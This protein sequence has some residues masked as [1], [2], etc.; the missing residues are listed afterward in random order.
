MY[1]AIFSLVVINYIDRV[2]LSMGAPAI[3]K[4]FN[5]GPVKLGYLFSSYMW[6]YL[7]LLIPWGLM[8]D[9]FGAKKINGVGII[10]WSIATIFS[11]LSTGFGMLLGSR[12]LMG[13]AEASS[14]PGGGRAL[15]D[16]SPKKEYGLAAT[17]LNSGGYAGPALGTFFLGWVLS[18][19]N[20]RCAFYAAALLGFVWFII[21][22]FWYKKPEDA[23]WLS[24]D[25]R[26]YIIRERDNGGSIDADRRTAGFF[27]L[28]KSRTMI[29]IAIAQGCAVYTQIVF[30]T[31]LPSYLVHVKH[32]SIL[33]SGSFTALPYFCATILSWIIAHFS[34]RILA[35]RGSAATGQRRLIIVIAMLT[36]AVILFAPAVQN[37]A[38]ILILITISLT[39]LA[40]GI[41]LNIALTA[42][43][44]RSPADAAKAMSIQ[45]SGGNIFGIAAPIV[46]GYIIALTGGYNMAFVAGGVLLII[47]A[48]ITFTLTRSPIGITQEA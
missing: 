18:I 24:D 37:A 32:L 4:E 23:K 14:Y 1:F 19:S 40:T 5:L 48:F 26:A 20:W 35:R 47:G 6:I 11:G 44:L 31:W 12:M 22:V 34:D 42:D 39:G 33:K 27:A 30:L 17:M 41:S 8:A 36:A 2:A 9:R 3:G 28:L 38:I 7:I 25:E 46:T 43:L 13:G 15:R 45:I 29:V 21:W 16:W 10:V